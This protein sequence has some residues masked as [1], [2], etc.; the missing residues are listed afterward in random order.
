MALLMWGAYFKGFSGSPDFSKWATLNQ[1]SMQFLAFIVPGLLAGWLCGFLV[2]KTLINKL[3]SRPGLVKYRWG[4]G[5]G[6]ALLGLLGLPLGLAASMLAS[7]VAGYKI[8]ALAESVHPVWEFLLWVAAMAP[9]TL[10]SVC[11]VTML[12]A[13]IGLAIGLLLHFAVLKLTGLPA[14]LRKGLPL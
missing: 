10:V 5:I 14:R 4:G 12:L 7:M 3:L 11:S 13:V 8:K 6:A 9:T 1:A 2:Q